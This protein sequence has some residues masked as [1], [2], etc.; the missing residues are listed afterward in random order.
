MEDDVQ[1]PGDSHGVTEDVL[2]LFPP[3]L[4]ESWPLGV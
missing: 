2:H 1:L 4:Q 3:F